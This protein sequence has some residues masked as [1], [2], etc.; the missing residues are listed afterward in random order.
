MLQP[1]TDKPFFK[2]L[3]LVYIYAGSPWEKQEL[4]D[5]TMQLTAYPRNK[6]KSNYNEVPSLH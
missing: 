3:Y 1:I 2:L 5:G 6:I 4:R